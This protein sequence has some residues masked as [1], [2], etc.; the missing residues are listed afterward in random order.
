MDVLFRKI[1]REKKSSKAVTVKITNDLEREGRRQK[2]QNKLIVFTFKGQKTQNKL[3]VFTFKVQKT[4]NKLI[5]ITIK[6]QKTQ[7]PISTEEEKSFTI[8]LIP[9]EITEISFSCQRKSM[10]ERGVCG[11]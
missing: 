8:T 9:Q 7:I 11:H 4:Q 2:T 3:I 6:G 10:A 1:S 5:V